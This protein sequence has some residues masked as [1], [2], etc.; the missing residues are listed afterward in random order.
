MLQKKR[1]RSSQD[2]SFE[3]QGRDRKTNIGNVRSK[4]KLSRQI[5]KCVKKV[6]KQD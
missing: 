5:K 1:S 6:C 2:Y 3:E 4:I